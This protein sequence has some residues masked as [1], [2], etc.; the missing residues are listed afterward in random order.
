MIFITGDV[1]GMKDAGKFD[2]PYFR[3]VINKPGNTIIITGDFGV[4]W[5]MEALEHAR[6]YYSQFDCQF[7]FIDGNNENFDILNSLPVSEYAGGKVHEVSSNIKHLMRG[8]IFTIEG[9]TILAF[10]GADSWDAPDVNTFT[11][12]V[13][14]VSWWK[15]EKPTD[16]EFRNAMDNIRAH[17]GK[18]DIILS[19]ETTTKN[20]QNYFSWSITSTTCQMLDAIEA[21]T[22][23]KQWFFG[24]HHYDYII[25]NSQRCLF[26]DFVDVSHMEDIP[27]VENQNME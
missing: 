4:T 25:D 13:E 24:H 12:R 18:V 2:T 16:A 15:A 14:G 17:G 8:E 22:E 9:T 21:N 23:Y 7:L 27:Y 20:V 5:T 19:H 3:D 6:E 11:R 10:G 26:N 1:H